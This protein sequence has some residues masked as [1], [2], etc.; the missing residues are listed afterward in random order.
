MFLPLIFG[1]GLLSVK[2]LLS[3]V[4]VFFCF[5]LM[6]SAI[7]IVN[8]LADIDADRKHPVKKNRPVASGSINEVVA[9]CI[10]GFLGT[11]SLT[12]AARLLPSIPHVWMIIGAYMLLN[13]LYTYFLKHLAIIDV[14]VIAIGFVLRVLAGGAASNITVSPWLI[15]MVFILALFIAFG[16]RRD[17]LIRSEE[18]GPNV[19]RSV[20]NYTVGFVDQAMS[21]LASA[22]IVAYIIYTLQPEVEARFSS[23][24][25]YLTTIFV[26]AG[27]LR[28]MQLTIVHKDSG[29]P[30]RLM[31]RDPFIIICGILWLGSFIFIIYF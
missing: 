29:Q 31:L 5:S 12:G 14:S 23:G 6:A 21:M 25:V 19:R 8:D 24:Y 18:N 17:D 16:K 9:G 26:I 4:I 13:L 28:F 27:I 2:P 15:V 22:M 3:A 1:G 11:L 20:R 30:T 7:Y 10:A